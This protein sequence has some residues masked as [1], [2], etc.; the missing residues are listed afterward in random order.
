MQRLF[1]KK[2]KY[3]ALRP[4]PPLHLDH[5]QLAVQILKLQYFP[6]E[7]VAVAMGHFGVRNMDHLIVDVKVQL[8]T[9][10]RPI[11]TSR[12]L[13]MN[14][15]LG[16][17]LE[18]AVQSRRPLR[19]DH[20]LHLVLEAQQMDQQAL[21]LFVQVPLAVRARVLSHERGQLAQRQRGVKLQVA[22]DG[23]QHLLLLN[24]PFQ[25][26]ETKRGDKRGPTSSMKTCV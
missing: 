19:P 9:I 17:A 24:L 13:T 15:Y 5:V 12:T 8:R 1:E 25:Q 4:A 2:I 21:G 10:K 16:A 6:D 18:L 23:G 7:K 20:V 26:G 22:A 3:L 11:K 14:A